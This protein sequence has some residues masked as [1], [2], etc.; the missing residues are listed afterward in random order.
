MAIVKWR[1]TGDIPTREEL[2]HPDA[3]VVTAV[4]YLDLGPGSALAVDL[5]RAMVPELAKLLE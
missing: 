3:R 4:F 5:A 1:G 2:D